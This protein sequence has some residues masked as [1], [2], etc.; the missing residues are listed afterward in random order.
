LSLEITTGRIDSKI[1]RM[2][3]LFEDSSSPRNKIPHK[4]NHQTV[5]ELG[6]KFHQATF[7]HPRAW[8]QI[9]PGDLQSSWKGL[10]TMISTKLVTGKISPEGSQKRRPIPQ[11]P[12]KFSS[13]NKHQNQKIL[14][15][16]MCLFILIPVT[17]IH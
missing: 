16:L 5:R 2:L 6:S 9:P 14:M 10:T 11:N 3:T 1:D 12:S 8:F 13:F 17:V 4:N 15:C 7:N